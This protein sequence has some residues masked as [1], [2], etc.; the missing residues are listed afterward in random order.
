MPMTHQ[1]SRG[2]KAG[3]L[4]PRPAWATE[5]DQTTAHK[6]TNHRAQPV[7]RTTQK[8]DITLCMRARC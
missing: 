8:T 2:T 5:Q 6:T 7:V 1:K 4:N 3:L